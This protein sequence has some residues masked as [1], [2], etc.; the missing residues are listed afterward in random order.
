MGLDWG[1]GR[2]SAGIYDDIPAADSPTI[3]F[4]GFPSQYTKTAGNPGH[5]RTLLLK[6]SLRRLDPVRRI[7]A[8]YG[9]SHLSPASTV[10]SAGP[11]YP[12]TTPL[13]GDPPATDYTWTASTTYPD[14]FS[15]LLVGVEHD[16]STCTTAGT[17]I[18]LKDH[19]GASPSPPAAERPFY[20]RAGV[21]IERWHAGFRANHEEVGDLG[22]SLDLDRLFKCFFHDWTSAEYGCNIQGVPAVDDESVTI[23]NMPSTGYGSDRFANTAW[24]GPGLNIKLGGDPVRFRKQITDV[25]PPVI[26][27]DIDPPIQQRT[28]D[29]IDGGD[30]SV[31]FV[32]AYEVPKNT[33]FDALLRVQKITRVR[34]VGGV[35]THTE[36]DGYLITPEIFY[37]YFEPRAW[38]STYP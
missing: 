4:T 22:F 11:Y 28:H 7:Q 24:N 17:K 23:E 29:A 8:G 27:Y 15:L 33:P 31:V 9:T 16:G 34:R 18:Y 20:D 36:D 3:F 10:L 13:G 26:A 19:L 6:D 25:S 12:E 32:A 21:A 5:T 1:N 38:Y 14:F 37:H 35:V 30:D 2:N